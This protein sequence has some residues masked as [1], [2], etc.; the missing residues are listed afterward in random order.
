VPNIPWA[1]KFFWTLPKVLLGDEDQLEACFGLFG[2]SANLDARLVH[3][4]RQ[5]YHGL[6]NHF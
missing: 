1:L 3:G 5:K 6:R 4:L 2:D